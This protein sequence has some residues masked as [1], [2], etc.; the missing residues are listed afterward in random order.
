MMN[1]N[2][3]A[4]SE[5]YSFID[6]LPAEEYRMI[7]EDVVEYINWHRDYSYDFEYDPT[8]TVDE[9]NISKE[10]RALILKLFLEYFANEERKNEINKILSKNQLKVDAELMMKN[11]PNKIFKKEIKVEEIVTENKE[12]LTEVKENIII[13]IKNFIL[14]IF[15]KN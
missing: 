9:Q 2:R 6:S 13:K 15:N 10:G 12:D 3:V 8:K 11:N 14:K 4:Y 7:P 1:K 5:A